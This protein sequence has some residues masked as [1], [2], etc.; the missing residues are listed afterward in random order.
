MHLLKNFNPTKQTICYYTT[1]TFK[2]IVTSTCTLLLFRH[3][4]KNSKAD[5]YRHLLKKN[6]SVVYYETT[7]QDKRNTALHCNI[8]K[9]KI[10]HHYFNDFL[11]L[12]EYIYKKQN[13]KQEA[14]GLHRSDKQQFFSSCVSFDIYIYIYKAR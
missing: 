14:S 7:L 8:L 2:C 3:D 9:I 10:K 11:S 13:I 12:T 1:S 6:F 5:M 4:V